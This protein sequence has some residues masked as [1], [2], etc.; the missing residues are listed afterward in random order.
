VEG[1]VHISEIVADRHLHHPQDVLKP[2]QIVR[3]QV[4]AVDA[5]KRQLKLSMKQLIPTSLD[6]YLAEHH[7]GD[8]VSGRIVDESKAHLTVELGEGIRVP[9][10]IAAVVPANEAA[11]PK[12]DL[13]SLS[14]MLQA[15]WKGSTSAGAGKSA[16]AASEPP[17]IGQIRTFKIVNIDSEAKKIEVGLV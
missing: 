2:G 13:S 3:A 15:R 5:E 11:A 17:R 4:L 12:A 7:V 14:S 10:H 8:T 16:A 9:C 1:L 6:E